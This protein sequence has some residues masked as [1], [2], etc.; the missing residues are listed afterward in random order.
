M[1][2]EHKFILVP[3]PIDYQALMQSN[4]EIPN[5]IDSVDI[6]DDL[7][8]YIADSLK[9]IPSKNP[10]KSISKEERGINYYGITLFDQSSAKVM[11][12]VFTSWHSLFANAPENLE[13]TGAFMVSSSK[14]KLGEYERLVFDRDEIL[15]LL[16]RLV[17][18]A[19][20]L[21]DGHLYLYHWGI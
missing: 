14:R 19:E 17:S 4:E 21:E 15:G 9:W 11:K 1:S 18:M 5:I 6:P 10:A 8:Q 2:L 13:L 20:K 16:E 12:S 7:V 3:K